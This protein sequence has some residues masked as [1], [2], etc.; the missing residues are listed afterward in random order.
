MHVEVLTFEGCPNGQ[1]A[2]DLVHELAGELGVDL[3]MR[4][5]RV[6]SPEE[7]ERLR[8]LGSPTIRVDE[9]DVE[10]GAEQRRDYV[11]ACRVYRTPAGITG[12]PDR[13]WVQQA[14]AAA[15]KP[16]TP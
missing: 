10:P 12:V 5:T 1:R 4:E 13:I 9:K 7:A 3:D 11:L 14:L 6:E 15:A 16:S 2:I 8:F